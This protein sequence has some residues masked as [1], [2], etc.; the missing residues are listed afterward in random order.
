MDLGAFEDSGLRQRICVV[1]PTKLSLAALRFCDS[2]AAA[3]D[4]SEDVGCRVFSWKGR[5]TDVVPRAGG[6]DL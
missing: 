6:S 1:S 5:N 4:D 2:L 3:E